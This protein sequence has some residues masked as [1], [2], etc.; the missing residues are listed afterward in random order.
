VADPALT[1]ILLVGGAG[2]R[3]GSPKPLAVL[4]GETLAERSWRTLGRVA[5]D[6]VAV[7]KASDGLDLPFPVADDGSELRAPLAGIVAGLRAAPGD[8]S[9]VVPVDMPL[10]GDRELR[11]L[12]A[13]CTGAAAVPQI[14]PLPCA[15]RSGARA[16]L[17]RRLEAGELTLRDA[18]AELDAAVVDLEP[19]ALANVNTPADLARLECR[20]VQF[21]AAHAAGFRELVAATL[22]EFGF[23]A[24][25]DLDPDLA[26]ASGVYESLWVAERD[27]LV[28]GS[29]A[30][31]RL[32]P[33]EMELKRMYLLPQERGRG[34]GR[35]LLETALAWA[36]A[37]GIATVRLDTTDRM[38]T[39][40]RLYEAYGFV[41]VPGEA[42][43]QGQARLLY[44]LRLGCCPT[45]GRCER[46]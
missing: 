30:L 13:G 25:P 38:E 5:S 7:G 37:H 23:S 43:R 32:G 9:L 15:L 22:A 16:V 18:V 1:G 46:G 6:R 31:R 11:A 14:G 28:V 41:E 2:R 26:D 40:R 42:P 34:L 45:H 24:D 20:I 27:G 44:E 39:A 12:A 33:A 10:V 21:A 17:E 29:V 36:G 35:Q 19:R 8:L 3:F 4:D